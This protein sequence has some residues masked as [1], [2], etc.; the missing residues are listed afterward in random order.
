MEGCRFCEANGAL[1]DAVVARNDHCLLVRFDDP[2]LDSWMMVLPIRHAETP[3]DLTA[4]EWAATR[5]LL[6]E[7]QQQLAVDHPDGYTIGRNV[8]S[9]GGRPSRT[10]TCM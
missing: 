1:V 5:A 3:F 10:L 4:E 7:A 6:S 9:V 2:V 8:H